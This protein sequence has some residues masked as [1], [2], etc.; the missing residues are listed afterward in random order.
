MQSIDELRTKIDDID[1][2]ILSLLN[3]RM[4]YVQKIGELKQS[5]KTAI[6]RPERERAILSRLESTKD[7]KLSKEAIEAI[8]LE[9]F[10]VSR[11]L[12]MPQKV[13]F[14]G[15]IGT[16]THQAAESRF[17]AMS[18][19]TALSS[20]EAVFRELDNKEA[21]YGVVPIENNT[22]GAVGITLDCLRKYENV[23]IVA[24]IYMDI[25]HSFVSMSENLKDIKKIY[26]HPQGYN[27]C[28]RFLDDHNL[29]EVTFIPTK[30]TAEAA[31]L[32]S[33]EKDSAA[34]CSKIAAHI[35]NVPIVFDT[36]E[37]NLANRTRFFVLSDFKN[38]KSEHNKTSIL[39][40]TAHRPGGLVELLSMF[41]N[42][43]INLTKLESRPIKQ[44][45]FQTVFYID[46]EG[47][48]D[49]ENIKKVLELA[50]KNGHDITWLGSYINQ[51]G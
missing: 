28:R 4:R 42:E 9:I 6:Y 43:G 25:H 10:A 8:Y 29:N 7:N 23:K 20:I 16:Y 50:A 13:A 2:Q 14:L 45:D 34:I 1:D 49:E 22:E 3:N 35:N 41:K 32:A 12:E 37:D 38:G 40:K 51:E 5:S 19:Y 46:F 17:G 36:I 18:S 24:E 48:I 47:H 30:S 44:K 27:Q 11:N 21:K 39:A 33:K 26:S 15:P 31:F